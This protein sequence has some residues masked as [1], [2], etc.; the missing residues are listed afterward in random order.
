MC[1]NEQMILDLSLPV[2][3]DLMG[4]ASLHHGKV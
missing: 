3:V 4:S 1:P 2:T